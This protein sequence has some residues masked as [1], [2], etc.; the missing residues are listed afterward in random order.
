MH[1]LATAQQLEQPQANAQVGQATA[2]VPSVVVL[3][4]IPQATGQAANF[5]SLG[6]PET[7]LTDA[8]YDALKAQAA[9]FPD[10]NG[11]SPEEGGS[12]PVFSGANRGHFHA[13]GI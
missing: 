4:E 11:R 10:P 6:P 7:G 9:N 5:F 3:G 8:Q 12:F 13:G 1:N 2:G